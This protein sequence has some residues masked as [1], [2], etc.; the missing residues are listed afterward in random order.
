MS[1]AAEDIPFSVSY[2]C[3]TDGCDLEHTIRWPPDNP[4]TVEI[5]CIKCGE[6]LS[7]PRS[8]ADEWVTG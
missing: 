6:W 4:K 1:D 8:A 2:D 7:V 3:P 5:Q